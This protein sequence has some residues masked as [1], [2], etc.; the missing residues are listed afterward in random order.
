M[1]KGYLI[2]SAQWVSTVQKFTLSIDLSTRLVTPHPF[3]NQDTCTL[4]RG[5]IVYCVEDVDNPWVEDH[6]KSVH[7][8]PGCLV[9][10]EDVKCAT[11]GDEYVGLRVVQ[12]AKT[13][14]IDQSGF[15]P[16]AEIG[17]FRSTEAC[18][19][20]TIDALRFVPYF[21][22]ANRAGRGQS[23]VGLRRWHKKT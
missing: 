21:F 5:P 20:G 17:S 3:T 8:D 11:T 4:V 19:G 10:E 15:R 9:E 6:F 7:I 18:G 23:R 14:D 22:R 12:G 16:A 1:E 13:V 2:L